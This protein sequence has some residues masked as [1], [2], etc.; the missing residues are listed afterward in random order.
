MWGVWIVLE[1][2]QIQKSFC[3]FWGGFEVTVGYV[4]QYSQPLFSLTGTTWEPRSE[5]RIWRPR[6]SGDIPHP[7]DSQPSVSSSSVY[8]R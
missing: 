5:R 3:F 4:P 7:F 1:R 2:A 6:T 8:A